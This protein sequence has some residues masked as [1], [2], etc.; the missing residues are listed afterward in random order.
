MS[1]TEGHHPDPSPILPSNSRRQPAIARRSFRDRIFWATISLTAVAAAAYATGLTG[2]IPRHLA[3][4]A[5]QK[6]D[7]DSA[8]DWLRV[9]GRVS[10]PSGETEFLLARARRKQGR[11]DDLRRHLKNAADLGYPK[12]VLAREELLAQA[13][14]GDITT[15]APRLSRWL[16]EPGE[17][18]AEICEAYANGCL[19]IQRYDLAEMILKGWEESYPQDPAPHLLRGRAF[20]R[21]ENLRDAEAEYRAA[22]GKQS[23][24]LPAAFRLGR[25]LLDA[26]RVDE[27]LAVFQVESDSRHPAPFWIGIAQCLLRLG[28]TGD[29]RPYLTK[30]GAQSLETVRTDYQAAGE[31]YEFDE[32]ALELGRLELSEGHYA[33][34][35]PW[36]ERALAHNA[37]DLDARY[38][39][40][41]AWRSL[42]RDTDSQ[43][44]IQRVLRSRKA[45][46]EVGSLL[47]RVASHADDVEARYRIGTLFLE[48]GSEMTGVFWLKSVLSYDPQHTAA[49]QSLA[50]YYERLSQS[51]PE[52]RTAAE[53]HRKSASRP[54]PGTS[55][56]KRSGK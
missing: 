29:A 44:E 4:S 13:Q 20:E 36:F 25:L 47:E 5:L 16:E 18:G 55:G 1:N 23:R 31:S 34:A 52:F 33:E 50:N 6:R 42:G 43:E 49:H 22:L 40:A 41:I 27:A 7:V 35:V 17:D 19:A 9:V 30:A 51:Q 12:D 24:Y 11:L 53:R 32:A 37:H 26:Q 14:T 3:R 56:T 2:T 28:R 38:S 10:P 39:R 48:H 21:G 45:L 8:L 15:I 46:E 54:S